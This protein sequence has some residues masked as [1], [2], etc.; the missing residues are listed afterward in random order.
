MNKESKNTDERLKDIFKEMP[1]EKPS[2]NFTEILL[3]RLEKEKIKEERKKRC[4]TVLQWAISI[5][6][7]FCIPALAIYLCMIFIPDF[8]FSFTLTEIHFNPFILLV[9]F[10]ILLL[11]IADILLEK[12]INRK[13]TDK[14]D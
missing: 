14:T 6:S 5:I 4:V 3:C 1:L 9:G 11:L 2:L 13:K 8:S 10:S 12:Y 7:L